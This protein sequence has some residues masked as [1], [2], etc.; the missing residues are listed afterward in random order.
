MHCKV[1]KFCQI[2]TSGGTERQNIVSKPVVSLVIPTFPSDATVP[3]I[4]L[5]CLRTGQVPGDRLPR[6]WTTG[7]DRTRLG[8]DSELT[9]ST[10]LGNSICAEVLLQRHSLFPLIGSF[11]RPAEAARHKATLTNGSFNSNALPFSLQELARQRELRHCRECVS[12]DL[13]TH[14]V[15]HWR[16]LHQIPSIRY[17][18]THNDL[19]HNR[20]ASCSASASIS[21][22]TLPGEP[23]VHCGS[24]RTK[25]DFPKNMSAGYLALLQLLERA[26]QNQAPE[27]SPFNR[28]RLMKDYKNS[29]FPSNATLVRRVLDWWSVRNLREL[30]HLL[31]SGSMEWDTSSIDFEWTKKWSISLTT[32]FVAYAVANGLN[33]SESR[34]DC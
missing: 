30:L 15:A 21:T 33:P 5:A 14:G 25:S 29:I 4:Y 24:N 1:S 9:A 18:P 22:Q 10:A 12:E 20:C 6:S 2:A 17:C 27:L 23:C 31:Q 19:L 16:R 34:N 28:A 8:F 32:T 3:S 7:R 26:L 13:T 11:L